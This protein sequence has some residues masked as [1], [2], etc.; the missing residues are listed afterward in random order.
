MLVY[1][2]TSALVPLL[3]EE[4]T[5]PACR[6]LWDASDDVVSTP[7]LYVEAV[8]ALTRAERAGSHR[9]RV[10]EAALVVLEDCWADIRPLDVAE[11]LVH[12]AAGHARRFGL[13]GY[14]AVHCAAAEALAGPDLIAAS[15]DRRLLSAWRALGLAVFD[16]N[17]PAA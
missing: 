12:A 8:A 7:L 5:S 15:G 9:R 4:P 1:L 17:L 16:A 6:A 10:V 3:I 14:D 2:D 11:P 13:R